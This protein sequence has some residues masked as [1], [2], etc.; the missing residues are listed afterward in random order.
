MRRP[1]ALCGAALVLALAACSGA[2]SATTTTVLAPSELVSTTPAGTTAV[3]EVVW[4]LAT[5]EPSSIDPVLTGSDSQYY[6]MGNMCE[7]LLQVDESFAIGDGLAVQADYDE[8]GDFVIDIRPGVTFWDGTSLTAEDVVYS[9]RRSADPASGSLATAAF[10]RV[11]SISAVGDDQVVVTFTEHD[12]QFRNAMAGPAGYVFE[13]DFTEAAGASFG[14]SAGGV[15]CT[16]PFEYTSWTSGK[17]I[18]LSANPDY[19]G[20][21]PLVGTLRFAFTNDDTTLTNALLAG[22]IDGAFAVPVSSVPSLDATGTVYFGPSNATSSFGPVST[23]GAAADPRIRK[24]LSLAIDRDS[25]ITGVLGGYGAVGR[26]F[27]PPFQWEGL[28]DADVYQAGYEALDA[29]MVD[30]DAAKAL[31]AEADP[32]DTTLSM[33]VASGDQQGLQTATV[34]QS[35]AV[36]IGLEV[37]IVQLPGTDFANLFYDESMR[38][39]YDLVA[40]TGYLDTPG[41]Y[42]YASFFALPGGLFNWTGYEDADVSDLL[43]EGRGAEDPTEAAQDFVAAQAIYADDYLQVTLAVEYARTYLSDGLTGVTTSF[44]HISTP[45]ALH[46]GAV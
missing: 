28:D 14:T 10:E 31:V 39:E 45:W 7:S 4:G 33:V 8:S 5:G 6:V 22:E 38:G 34:V 37:E 2:Q 1:P 44:A 24:A 36:Q 35:A 9:L 27:T 46:L 16:G 11:G 21:A 32:Q 20:G 42:A 13:K 26:T 40:T 41:A 43:E 25:Y 3:D 19:W 29:P 12:S 18:V 30:L 23:T 15:M 17:D